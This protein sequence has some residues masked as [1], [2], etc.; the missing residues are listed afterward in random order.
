MKL[1]VLFFCGDK[2]P[3]GLAHLIPILKSR[4]DLVAVVIPTEDRWEYFR[5]ALLGKS[6]YKA[7][8]EHILMEVVKTIIMRL[9]PTRI[10]RLVRKGYEKDKDINIVD[11]L[12]VHDISLIRVFDINKRSF[13]EKVKKINPD[14]I[15][16]AAY[17]QI[18]S[19]E[20]ILIPSK[21]SINFHPSL[22]PRYR[23]A[24]PHFWAIVKGEKISGLT[25][26]FMTENI[27]DG[28]IIAQID[29]PI[30]Q[31]TY[32]ELYKKIIQ[33]TPNLVKLVESFFR[34]GGSKAKPQDSSEATYFRNDREIHRRIFWDIHTADEIRNLCRTEQAFCFFRGIKVHY[35]KAYVT[36]SN[37]NLTNDVRVE[38]GT[39]VDIYKDA[40]V[41]KTKDACINI[42]EFKEN[43]KRLPL[44]KWVEK[45]RVNIGEKFD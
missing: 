17:P 10:I 12:G 27:D 20:L 43:G 35:L 36:D 1:R 8:S 4:F 5:E 30:E 3:Y 15:F 7:K 34:E 29:F 42:Q 25:A 31:Y 24:H 11:I 16:S 40:I 6:Y 18:F 45:H 13:I 44:K 9:V 32:S 22:L 14:I 38:N 33:E 26:H 39:I 2:S 23:G 19:K 21:G 41:V 37:R 28:D